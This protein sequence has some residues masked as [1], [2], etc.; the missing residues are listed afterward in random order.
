MFG[1]ISE[2][3]LQASDV[4]WITSSIPS[5]ST[6]FQISQGT[7]ILPEWFVPTTNTSA[8]TSKTYNKSCI[9]RLCPSFLCQLVLTLSGKIRKPLL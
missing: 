2:K 7:S 5:D 3:L 6:I 8:F 1:D 4:F 9:W